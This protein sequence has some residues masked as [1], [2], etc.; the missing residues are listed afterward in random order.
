MKIYHQV[1]RKDLEF[2]NADD[3]E[4]SRKPC[5]SLLALKHGE[6]KASQ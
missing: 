5:N 2:D 1:G 4:E 3:T 6:G